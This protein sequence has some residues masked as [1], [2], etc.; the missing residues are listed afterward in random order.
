MKIAVSAEGPGLDA[1]A[2]ERLGFASYLLVVDLESKDFEAIRSPRDAGNGAGMQ[3]VALIIARKCDVL[4]TKWCSP[5]AEKYLTAYG[6]AVV[7]DLSGTVA[8]VLDQFERQNP[9]G[10]AGKPEDLA[11]VPWKIEREAVMQALRSASHQIGNLLPVMIGVIFLT[12]LFMTFMSGV[13]LPSLFSGG[14]WR[15]SFWGA[16][17]G[18]LFA[19]NAINSYII[20]GQMLE[21]G[22]SVIAVTAFIC[23]WVTVGLMQLPAEIAALGWRFA[24]VRNASCFGLSMGISFGVFIFLKLFEV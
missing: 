5:T 2:G 21:A 14:V 18:S 6:V 3:M 8:E 17:L 7:R 16:C 11:R 4:L 22:V 10:H 12:G 1:K 15:D 13:F 24:V 23:S 20:G 9:D 19:G